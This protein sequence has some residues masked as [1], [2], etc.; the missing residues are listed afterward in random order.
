[1]K[2]ATMSKSLV[3][4]NGESIREAIA[5]AKPDTEIKISSEWYNEGLEIT[6]N[7]L[8]L[9]PREEGGEVTITQATNPCLIVD[10]GEG[11]VCTINNLKMLLQ[12]PNKDADINSFQVGSDFEMKANEKCMKEFFAHKPDDLYC[13]ILVRS[14]TLRMNGCTLSLDGIFKETH[15]KVPCVAAMPGSKIDFKDC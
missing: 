8:T 2:T 1:M 7:N 13:I 15:K 9:E 5:K 4:Q 3:S 12:G 11:N 6:K 14:G 10:V